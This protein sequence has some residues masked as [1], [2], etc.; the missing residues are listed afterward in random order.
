MNRD[1]FSLLEERERLQYAI[2]KPAPFGYSFSMLNDPQS[3]PNEIYLDHAATS[4]PKPPGVIEAVV[5][6]SRRLGASAGRGDYPR[7]VETGEMLRECRVRLAALLGYSDPDR[8]IFTLN[9]TDA[10]TVALRGLRLRSGDVVIVGPTEHNSVMRPLNAMAR[11]EGV[12]VERLPCDAEGFADLEALERALRGN[13]VRLV[14]LQHASNVLGALQDIAAAGSL[15]RAAGVPL[16]VDAAQTAGGI[17]IRGEEWGVTYLAVPGHKG[18]QG[19][20]GTGA[21]L[22]ARE[23]DLEPFR[24]GGT[25]SVSEE[26]EH[27]RHYPDRLEA[28]SHNAFGLAGL[29]AALRW[30]GERGI[31][32]IRRHE[33]RLIESFLKECF[34]LEKE[35]VL[36]VTGPRDFERKSPVVAVDIPGIDPK[37]AARRL[38]EKDRIMVRPG[39]HCAPGAHRVAGTW[40]RGSVRFSFGPMTTEEEISRA[41]DALRSVAASSEVSKRATP[42]VA[43][44]S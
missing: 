26:E 38:W 14:A 43:A 5:E 1:P 42:P 29:S 7:A 23:A 2:N 44:R 28:G 39:L 8:V 10:L 33:K 6:W 35:G 9:C 24:M 25:G 12:R 4:F 34:A 31:G 3:S 21:L 19:P 41:L 32:T 18:L 30:L 13:R 40:P 37:E 27:P 15:C 36:R 16:L 22:I 17:E 11:E 20:L